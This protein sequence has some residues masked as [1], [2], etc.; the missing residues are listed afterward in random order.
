[1]SK[2]QTTDNRL[3]VVAARQRELLAAEELADAKMLERSNRRHFAFS[4]TGIP[5]LV[6]AVNQICVIHPD[7]G[8]NYLRVP[9]QRWLRPIYIDNLV[10]GI[11]A[12]PTRWRFDSLIAWKTIINNDGK[13]GYQSRRANRAPEQY[14]SAKE[15]KAS[16][17]EWLAEIIPSHELAGLD[18]SGLETPNVRRRVVKKITH[19]ATN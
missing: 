10:V 2:E 1:M 18:I 13:I 15:L 9:L 4:E 7:S 17:V 12:E 3:A 14:K 8:F 19:A 11:K 6:A 16:F 5:D